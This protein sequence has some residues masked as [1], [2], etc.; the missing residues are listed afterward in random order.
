MSKPRKSKYD[1]SKLMDRLLHNS[2]T[3]M[4]SKGFKA[5]LM[6]AERLRDTGVPNGLPPGTPVKAYQVDALPGC[7]KSWVGGQGSYV[8]PIDR[9][10]GL[11]FDWTMNDS[12]N[13]GV[14]ASVKGMNPITG[15]KME[16]LALEQYDKECPKCKVEFQGDKFCPKC[17]YKWP[18]QN[19]VASPNVLWWDGF[20]QTD[21]TVRQFFFSEDESRDIA[22]HVIGKKNTVPAFGFAFYE[23]VER[24]QAQEITRGVGSGSSVMSFG[25]FYGTST[26]HTTVYYTPGPYIQTGKVFPA[27]DIYPQQTYCVCST[28]EAEAARGLDMGCLSH[29]VKTAGGLML[30]SKEVSVGGG[31]EIMQDL[32]P[33]TLQVS[34]WRP[35]PSAIIRLYFVF[36]EEF[37]N[38]VSHGGIRD[39]QGD[40]AGFMKGLPLG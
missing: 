12:L 14:V 34:Q 27:G 17:E 6:Q 10:M 25:S 26:G 33:D 31:A 7:P 40:K 35:E 20:R 8:C 1:T 5:R 24:R 19:Y 30:A 36:A 9:D 39:L 37:E 32:V 38:I 16:S 23:S 15:Q 18:P 3:V 2:D 22:S 13:T 29:E 21:G 4:E 28:S 11:W